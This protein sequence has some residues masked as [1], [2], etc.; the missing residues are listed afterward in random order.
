MKNEGENSPA[1]LF[2][3]VDVGKLWQGSDMNLFQKISHDFDYENIDPDLLDPNNFWVPLTYRSRVIVY[4]NDRVDK[5]ELSTYEDLANEKWKNRLLVRSSSNAYNQALMS[6]LIANL[7]Y[8]E[9]LKWTEAVVSNFAR[10]PKGSDRDQV[11]AIAAGQ[12]DIAIVNSY[13]IG[14]LL[15]SEKEEEINAGK[16][17]SVFFSKSR[18]K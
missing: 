2:I 1:D 3:T 9:T 17:V 7:G 12:G 14:L 5:N 11:K 16:S 4:S 8:E 10:D 13:Y 6:S 18:R 15:S